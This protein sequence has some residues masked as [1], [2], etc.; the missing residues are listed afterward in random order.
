MKRT[1]NAVTTA[2]LLWT[3]TSAFAQWLNVPGPA[4]P[5]TKDGKPDLTAPAPRRPDGKPDLSGVWQLHK[6]GVSEDL[7]TYAKPAE[8]PIQP[9][10][11]ALAKQ[12]QSDADRDLPTA[13]CL[14]AGIPPLTISSVAYPMK[15]VQQSDLLVILYEWFGEVRQIFMDGRTL[16]KDPNPA[17]LG[18]STGH[19]DG[20]TLVVETTGFN[21]KAWLDGAGRPG[22]EALHL[23]ERYQRRDVGHIEV[24]IVVDDPKAY[25]KPWSV[26]LQL[27]LRTGLELMEYVCDENERDARHVK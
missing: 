20:D 2:V 25:T 22:T 8:I 26:T 12:R 13:H 5:R 18:Y 21:G 11:E 27:E 23:T 14:P 16:S 19:W 6:E 1:R 15:I 17:W 7:A 4:I 10:A 9:W 3:A 24:Q